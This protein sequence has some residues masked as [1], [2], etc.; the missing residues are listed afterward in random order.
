M[1]VGGAAGVVPGECRLKLGHTIAISLL[2][3]AEVGGVDVGF[4][5]SVA[6]AVGHDA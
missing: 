1:D 4:V 6:V 3:T 2:D 5:G